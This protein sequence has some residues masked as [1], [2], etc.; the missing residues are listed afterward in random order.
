[1]EGGGNVAVIDLRSDFRA[2]IHLTAVKT[3][4]DPLRINASSLS[5]PVKLPPLSF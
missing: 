5:P 1:M 2:K 3:N 4:T